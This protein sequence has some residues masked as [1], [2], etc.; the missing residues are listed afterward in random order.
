MDE[1]VLFL[2]NAWMVT[3]K[4][5]P[6][7]KNYRTTLYSMIKKYNGVKHYSVAFIEII[8]PQSDKQRNYINSLQECI[9]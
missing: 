4:D 3:L 5:C 1:E 8:T 7:A 9:A 2:I 6:S